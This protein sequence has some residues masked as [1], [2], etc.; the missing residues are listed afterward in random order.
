MIAYQFADFAISGSDSS[1][2]QYQAMLKSARAGE[3]QVLI[4]DDLSRLSRDYI[5]AELTIRSLEFRGIRI[6]STSD[7]YDSSK[8]VA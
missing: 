8:R 1:R 2:P 3:F 4:I 7:G 5:E 6:V